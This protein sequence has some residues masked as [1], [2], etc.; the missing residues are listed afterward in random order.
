M[1]PIPLITMRRRLAGLILLASDRPEWK[2]SKSLHPG[3]LAIGLDR[4]Q[5]KSFALLQQFT[6]RERPF[7]TLATAHQ[8]HDRRRVLLTWML[9][10]ILRCLVV[11]DQ[12]WFCGGHL[13]PALRDAA[14]VA[15]PK[16]EHYNSS[17][18]LYKVSEE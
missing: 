3:G 9:S 6:L 1:F 7:F 15:L 4:D 10:G 13:V 2:Y 16:L 11:P 14:G 5:S 17:A 12:P 18:T 8:G